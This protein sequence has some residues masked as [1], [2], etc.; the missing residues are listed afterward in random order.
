MNKNKTITIQTTIDAPIE[1]VWEFWTIPEHIT[2]WNS[3]SSDWHTPWAEN[4]LEEGGNF[5]YRME[6]KNSFSGFDFKGKYNQI[7]TNKLITYTLEDERKVKITFTKNNDN[8][9]KI[10]ETFEAENTNPLE[11]QREGWQSIL[12][13]FRNYVESNTSNE[14][15]A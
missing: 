11:T 4:N 8:K 3:A 7:K 5:L 13:N 1:K 10:V 2:Q 15:S 12:D 6:D 14:S 9:T